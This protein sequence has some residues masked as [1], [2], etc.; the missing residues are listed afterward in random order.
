MRD[1]PTAEEVAD[2]DGIELELLR[3]AREVAERRMVPE[4]GDDQ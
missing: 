3:R 2:G 1:A 4:D